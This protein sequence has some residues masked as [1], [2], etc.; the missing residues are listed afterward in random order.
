MNTVNVKLKRL[1]PNA[2]IPKYA[3]DGDAGADL[4]STKKVV[5]EPGE[6]MIIPTGWA[7]EIPKGWEWQIRPRSGLS[8]K[9]KLMVINSPGTVDCG[10]RGEVGVIM[11][12]PTTGTIKIEAGERIAQAVLKEV[13]QAEF[14]VVDELSTTERGEGGFGSTGTTDV[15]KK[16]SASNT[17]PDLKELAKQQKESSEEDKEIKKVV[18]QSEEVAEVAEE[19]LPETT[20]STG[21]EALIDPANPI[22]IGND[23]TPTEEIIPEPKTDQGAVALLGDDKAEPV[24][25]PAKTDNI[26]DNPEIQEKVESIKEALKDIISEDTTDE[27]TALANSQYVEQE[28]SSE[29]EMVEE[30]EPEVEETETEEDEPVEEDSNVTPK[31]KQV[32]QQEEVT[33]TIN[34]TQITEAD[35]EK[36]TPFYEQAIEAMAKRK[37]DTDLLNRVRAITNEDHIKGFLIASILRNNK[38]GVRTVVVTEL[39][40]VLKEIEENNKK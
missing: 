16:E 27:P 1:K 10:Y 30:E 34:S 14:E 26:T 11:Y 23:D 25:V 21:N 20:T 33:F 5:L 8:Y 12:N 29:D 22:T 31:P 35:Y 4:Y 2:V 13:T 3:T 9:R 15:K 18:E 19:E 24:I 7:V 6:C 39:R 28:E 17:L 32:E 38:E 36:Y 40:N 37:E